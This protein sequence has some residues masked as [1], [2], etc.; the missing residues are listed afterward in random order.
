VFTILDKFKLVLL[1][2]FFNFG[3]Y[4][5]ISVDLY[6]NGEFLEESEASYLLGD[7]STSLANLTDFCDEF[8]PV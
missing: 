2:L 4:G 6:L 1:A 8:L 5:S 7:F 3:L